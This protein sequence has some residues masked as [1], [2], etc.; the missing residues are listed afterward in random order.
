M[1]C[2]TD[3]RWRERGEVGMV[4]P[5]LW[6]A[7]SIQRLREVEGIS[8]KSIYWKWAMSPYIV[9]HRHVRQ[10]DAQLEWS[11][12]IPGSSVLLSPMLPGSAPGRPGLHSLLCIRHAPSAT[13]V[14]SASKAIRST[15]ATQSKAG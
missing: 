11:E 14:N 8:M 15:F 1:S 2:Y 9:G 4:F 12:R 5:S 6:N 7:L 10:L 3:Y 13:R